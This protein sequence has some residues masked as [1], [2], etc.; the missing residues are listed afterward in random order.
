MPGSLATGLLALARASAGPQGANNVVY[1]ACVDIMRPG[2]ED[3]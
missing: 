1:D 3:I 2:V